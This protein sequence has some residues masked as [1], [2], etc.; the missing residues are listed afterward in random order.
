MQREIESKAWI[1][2]LDLVRARLE[3][4]AAFV[5]NVTKRDLYY[6]AEN[7]RP[8]QI[9]LEE[10]RVFRLR[11]DGGVWLVT[12]K[13]RSLEGEIELNGEIEFPIP[14]PAGFRMLAQY[15]GY[16]PFI[17]KRKACQVYTYGRTTCELARVD[18]LG[19]F[20][21]VEIVLEDPDPEEIKAAATE[22]KEALSYFAGPE[23]KIETRPYIDLLRAVGS[24]RPPQE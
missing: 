5:R 7:K 16:R 1:E 21:E 17:T 15:L 9:D 18:P 24:G 14:D 4:E 23:A 3:Q 2:D 19:D 13:D 8:E 6:G 11:N 22:V 20:L 12:A 10:D